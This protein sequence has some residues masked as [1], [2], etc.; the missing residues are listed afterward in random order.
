MNDEETVF[1]EIIKG[2]I[3]RYRLFSCWRG[4][5]YLKLAPEKYEFKFD[6]HKFV[7]IHDD[8]IT[9]DDIHFRIFLEL[10]CKYFPEDSLGINTRAILENVYGKW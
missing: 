2:D 10:V 3:G 1:D 6:V 8:R 5:D 4:E 7:S 9:V